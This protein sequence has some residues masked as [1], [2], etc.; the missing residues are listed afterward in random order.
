[1]KVFS[2]TVFHKHSSNWSSM[3]YEND[4][5]YYLKTFVPAIL[6]YPENKLLSDNIR[7]ACLYLIR[8]KMS[9]ESNK[10]MGL[11][12]LIA[13]IVWNIFERENYLI[14]VHM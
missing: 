14:K 11:S 3:K 13:I 2:D 9:I 5:E 1:M 10:S 8:N 6:L 7:A 12:M 4:R